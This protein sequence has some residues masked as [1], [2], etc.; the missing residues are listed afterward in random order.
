[1]SGAHSLVSTPRQLRLVLLKRRLVRI[2]FLSFWSPLPIPVDFHSL[3]LQPPIA[4]AVVGKMRD[5]LI[6][7]W[8]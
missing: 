3:E 2:P 8:A 4:G 7:N 6:D 5:T 1:M